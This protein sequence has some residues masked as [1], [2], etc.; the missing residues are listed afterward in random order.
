MKVKKRTY[1]VIESYPYTRIVKSN[2]TGKYYLQK[3]VSY[4]LF[5][6]KW[7]LI[8]SPFIDLEQITF[9]AIALSIK[10]LYRQAKVTWSAV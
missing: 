2:L 10:S 1:E 4:L 3:K 8:A 6:D 5:F 7:K 9:V